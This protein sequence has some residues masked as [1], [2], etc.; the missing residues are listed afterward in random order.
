MCLVRQ[1]SIIS[2]SS[3]IYPRHYYR[4]RHRL[5]IGKF[6]FA[7]PSTMADSLLNVDGRWYYKPVFPADFDRMFQNKALMPRKYETCHPCDQVTTKPRCCRC[8]R[9]NVTWQNDH[10]IQREPSG[11]I[12]TS[13]ST[14]KW[15]LSAR[16]Y[17]R[18]SCMPTRC[19]SLLASLE[20][21]DDAQY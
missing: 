3:D 17:T 14:A 20:R 4:R 8:Q 10:G 21:R 12:A 13:H 5:L 7:T 1:A 2:P 11:T 9:L 6:S 16:L 18:T 15:T 19:T